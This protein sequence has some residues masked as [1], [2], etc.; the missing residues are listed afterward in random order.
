MFPGGLVPCLLVS[1]VLPSI[2]RPNSSP[3]FF[4]GRTVTDA[5][6]PTRTATGLRSGHGPWQL[7]QR[8]G[9]LRQA[10]RTRPGLRRP[11]SWRKASTAGCTAAG[12]HFGPAHS[13]RY[14]QACPGVGSHASAATKL[15]GG[16]QT[17]ITASSA[18]PHTLLGVP[19]G[20]RLQSHRSVRGQSPGRLWPETRRQISLTPSF[21]CV[22]YLHVRRIL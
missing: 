5:V 21:H 17:P 4:P 2:L 7:R 19:W 18:R 15:G 12:R 9:R 22:L 8:W 10:G 6:A 3:H 20:S 16:T 14:L 13:P 11:G 1:L